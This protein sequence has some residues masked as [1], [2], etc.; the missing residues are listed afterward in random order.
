MLSAK[1]SSFLNGPH[2]GK[3]CILGPFQNGSFWPKLEAHIGIGMYF[4]YMVCLLCLQ[5]LSQHYYLKDSG[6]FDSLALDST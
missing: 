5:D 6:V 2:A 3:L 4:M 1:H